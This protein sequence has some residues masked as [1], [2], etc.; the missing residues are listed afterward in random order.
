IKNTPNARIVNVSSG[1]HNYGELDFEDLHW[2]RRPYKKMKAY[3]DSKIANIYFTHELQRRLDEAGSTTLVL[4]SHPGWTA[5][6]LQRHAG[7]FNFLNRFVAQDITMGALPT[8]CAAAADDVQACDYYGPSGWRE[9][10]GFPKKVDSNELSKDMA[11][12][13]KLWEVSEKLTGI[14]YP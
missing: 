1:A 14:T 3:G 11:I 7:V 2:E 12:A 6:E 10:R 4:S 9:M 8:L 5:T 13:K